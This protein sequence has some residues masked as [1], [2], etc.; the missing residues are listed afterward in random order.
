MAG[1]ALVAGAVR[2]GAPPPE[3]ERPGALPRF[4]ISLDRIFGLNAWTTNNPPN[5]FN[6][7]SSNGVSVSALLGAGSPDAVPALAYHIPREALDYVF[8]FR[9]TLGLGGGIFLGSSRTKAPDGTSVQGPG[10]FLFVVEPRVGYIIPLGAHAA[11]W[12]RVGYSF[13]GFNETGTQK[14]GQAYSS[15]ING[16]AIDI[17][18]AF[19][20]RPTKHAGITASLVGDIGF[21]GRQS[22]TPGSA[23]ALNGGLTFGGY[24]AF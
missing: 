15:S 14:N 9:L 13:Y 1:S 5:G 23:T 20:W 10:L 22:G 3:E 8:P 11:F 6:E 18:P 7:G 16:M 19:V 24:V 2:E 12:P 17:E 4:V 21:F